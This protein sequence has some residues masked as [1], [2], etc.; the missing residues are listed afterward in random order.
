MNYLD[1]TGKSVV[2]F[3]RSNNYKYEGEVTKENTHNVYLTDVFSKK[4][5]IPK[6]NIAKIELL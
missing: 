5:I 1:I 6:D 2:V 3:I 4:W